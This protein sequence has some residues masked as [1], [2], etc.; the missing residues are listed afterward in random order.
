LVA[1]DGIVQVPEPLQVAWKVSVSLVV[2][3]AADTQIVEVDAYW[4]WPLPSQPA[5]AQFAFAPVPAGQPPSGSAP[6][7]G[8]GEQVPSLFATPQLM[9]VPVQAVAQQ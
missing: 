9:Q 1:G 3:H 2:L 4:Q 8:T 5:V 7:T 6:L